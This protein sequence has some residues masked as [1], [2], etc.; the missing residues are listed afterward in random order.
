MIVNDPY[1]KNKTYD[2]FLEDNGTLNTTI[3]INNK[4]FTFSSE[5]ILDI[6]YRDKNGHLTENTLRELAE[7]I[8]KDTEVK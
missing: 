8:L 6:E 1:D 4:F 3:S 5:Y 2:V 7:S